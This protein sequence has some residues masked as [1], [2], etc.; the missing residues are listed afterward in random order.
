[1][2]K[3]NQLGGFGGGKESRFL[4]E[5][6][7]GSYTAAP[8]S[9]WNGT[10]NL[11][12]VGV[13]WS[14]NSTARTYSGFFWDGGA[15]DHA[16]GTQDNGDSEHQGIAVGMINVGPLDGDLDTTKVFSVTGLDNDNGHYVRLIGGNGPV[17]YVNGGTSAGAAYPQVYSYSLLRN[18]FIVVGFNSRSSST[19]SNASASNMIKVYDNGSAYGAKLFT[20]QMTE[21]GTFSTTLTNTNKNQQWCHFVAVYRPTP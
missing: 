17:T 3:L 5:Y 13:N 2:L 1:M 10:E 8:G 7:G 12:Y 16:M 14:G 20:H 6:A 18:D 11:A 15:G 9:T 19:P 4:Y 21:D